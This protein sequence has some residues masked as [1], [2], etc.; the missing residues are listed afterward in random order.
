MSINVII[1]L[2]MLLAIIIL[3]FKAPASPGVI[4]TG[5]P[6]IA[7]VL[8]GFSLKEVNGFI[9][10]GLKS[11][12]GTLFLMVFTVL[13]FGTLTETG[14]FKALIKF[15]ACCFYAFPFLSWKNAMA[16]G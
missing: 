7:A 15:S 1:T 5:V 9:G 12:S 13:Y 8:M 3:I 14:I 4:M 6:I 11:V 16:Q 2:I 10:N